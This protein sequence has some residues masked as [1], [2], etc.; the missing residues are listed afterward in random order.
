MSALDSVGNI[1]IADTDNSR[2]RV[3]CVVSG[4]A[5]CNGRTVG[6]I[7]TVA[8]N[9]SD[10]G[11]VMYSGPEGQAATYREFVSTDERGAGQR[12]QPVHL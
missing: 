12:R 1:Y 5:F 9:G 11:D 10:G 7:Y 8:G 6:N 3:V 2:V 4:G